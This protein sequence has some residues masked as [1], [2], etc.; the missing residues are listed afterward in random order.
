MDLTLVGEIVG[1]LEKYLLPLLLACLR[2]IAM[3]QFFPLFFWLR[4]TSIMRLAIAMALIMPHFLSMQPELQAIGALAPSAYVWLAMKEALLGATLGLLVGLPFWACQAA[5]DVIEVYRGANIANVGDPINASQTSVLGQA[6]LLIGLGL[7]VVVD[8]LLVLAQ[9]HM[10]SFVAWP[11]MAMSPGLDA[12]TVAAFGRG[13]GNL[14]ELGLLMT[15]PLMIVL[16]FTEFAAA[17]A[18]RGSKLS[19]LNDLTSTLKNL[20][21][22]IL[23][24]TYM[25]FVSEYIRTHSFTPIMD[26]LRL[27]SAR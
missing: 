16:F 3:V 12:S 24:P 26:Y 22:V 8:G 11:I 13:L 2:T 19:S 25:L 23:I 17:F 1:L 15:A 5:G 9:L 14:M 10:L 20:I 6:M 27:L 21:L 4:L 7:F 18:G